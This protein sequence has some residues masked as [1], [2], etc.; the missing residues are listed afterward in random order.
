MRISK[1]L[2]FDPI[3]DIHVMDNQS[4]KA[5]TNIADYYSFLSKMLCNGVLEVWSSS[6]EQLLGRYNEYIP[7]NILPDQTRDKCKELEKQWRDETKR[8]HKNIILCDK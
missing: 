2:L 6:D 3:Q 1:K 5:A 4:E 7:L 8:K